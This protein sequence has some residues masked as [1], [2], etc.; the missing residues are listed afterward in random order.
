[1][2][3]DTEFTPGPQLRYASGLL[4]AAAGK[5]EAAIEEPRGCALDHPIYGG[6]NPAN[7]P[8]RSWGALSLAEPGLDDE[9]REFAW[10]PS[11]E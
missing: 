1:M 7:L 10:P 2:R 8:W 4:R 5:H 3:F 11:R 6:E 9:A